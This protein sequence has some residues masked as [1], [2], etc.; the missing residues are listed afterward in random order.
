MT[1][2]TEGMNNGSIS[3]TNQLPDYGGR[4]IYDRPA[5]KVEFE[6]NATTIFRRLTDSGTNWA[7]Q[8]TSCGVVTGSSQAQPFGGTGSPRLE[9]GPA[10]GAP[11]DDFRLAVEEQ[12]NGQTLIV[13]GTRSFSAAGGSAATRLQRASDRQLRQ[14]LPSARLRRRPGSHA[15]RDGHVRPARRDGDGLRLDVEIEGEG[16]LVSDPVGID[17]APGLHVAL[18]HRQLRRIESDSSGR[19]ALRPL[20][21][22]L[23]AGERRHLHRPDEPAAAGA[24]GVRSLRRPRSSSRSRRCRTAR[25]SAS[26]SPAQCPARSAT[27]KRSS[28]TSTLAR[29]R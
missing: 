6:D 5:R 21:G 20:G 13:K 14:L 27:A 1:L 8:T 19:L 11:S 17:C 18:R 22:R 10:F 7:G 2:R 3:I 9:L 25:L 23:R 24:R 16:P 12:D 4:V 28:K 26:R 29:T 15:E